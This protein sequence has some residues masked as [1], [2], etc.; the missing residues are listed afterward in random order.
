MPA[1]RGHTQWCARDHR[2]GLKEH[3]A[4][5]IAFVVPRAGNGQLTRVF[6]ADGREY[7]EIR[8]QVPLPSS[9][10]GARALLLALL[11][12][13]PALLRPERQ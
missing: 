9:E 7:A 13:L 1:N 5:P 3:R 4:E 10:P 2:C 8:L 12:R 6:A 11:G